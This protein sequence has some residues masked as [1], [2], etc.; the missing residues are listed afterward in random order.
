MGTAHPD[1][2]RAAPKNRN[3]PH[4]R[5][6][7]ADLMREVRGLPEGSRCGIHPEEGCPGLHPSDDHLRGGGQLDHGHQDHRQEHRAQVQKWEEFEEDTTDGRH[8]KTIVTLDGNTMTTTQN[9]TK[10]GEK[11]VVV[12]RDFNDEGLTYKATCDGVTSTQK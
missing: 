10:A 5:N 9:A 6:I 1:T 7:H 2:I 12:V 4:H 8:C 11:N 3:G